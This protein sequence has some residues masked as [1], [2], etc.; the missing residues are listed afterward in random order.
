M[1]LSY[2]HQAFID[3]YFLHNQ[4]A[5]EAYCD[6]YGAD[7]VTGA[8]NGSKLLRNTKISEEIKR[9]IAENTASAD[10]VLKTITEIERSNL[11]DFFKVVEEWT[12]YPLPT[13]DVI[14]AKEVEIL[15]E[16]GKPT[17]EKKVSYWVRHI[18][19][20]I[21]KML[22]PKYGKLVNEFSDSRT[23][24]MKIKL[25]S[26]HEA[27]R[28]IGKYRG[29]FVERSENLNID[30]GTLTDDQLEMLK[31]GKDLKDVLKHHST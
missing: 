11:G 25:Y 30:L 7:R 27:A 9:R 19:L 24:G 15:D 8:V 28:D 6:V 12:F 18:V 2:K 21:D 16:D 26:R 22:D 20:D 13:Y 4:N 3:S 17:G 5:T 29:L 14:D 31:Q 1:G 10:E 23:H